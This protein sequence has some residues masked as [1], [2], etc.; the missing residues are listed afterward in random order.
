[1]GLVYNATTK[2][3]EYLVDLDGSNGGGGSSKQVTL[4]SVTTAPS[5]T[6]EK[7]S[8][9]YNSTN[10][11]IY[12]AVDDNTWTGATTSTP[13]FGVIYIYSNN[14]A[15]TYYQ[16]DGDNLVETDLEKYQLVANKT[17]DYTESSKNKYPSSYALYK[18]LAGVRPN[19]VTN[20][21]ATLPATTG[22]SLGDTFLNTSDKKLYTAEANVY[23]LN[24]T[25]FSSATISS[26]SVLDTTTGVLSNFGSLKIINIG[27]IN[28][29]NPCNI[30]IPIK[31]GSNIQNTQVVFFA[32]T[33]GGSNWYDQITI[34]IQNGKMYLNSNEIISV[35]TETKYII[36]IKIELPSQYYPN[37]NISVSVSDINGNILGTQTST[38]DKPSFDFVFGCW[39]GRGQEG[40]FFS[41]EIYA[42]IG[43][44][45]FTIYDKN[46][47]S[48]SLGWDSG[49]SLTEGQYL[50]TTNSKLIFYKDDEITEV[51]DLSGYKLKATTTTIDTASVTVSEIKANTNYVFSNNA[52]T[53]I[54]LTAC[55]TSFEETSINFTTGSSAPTFTD[56]ASIKWFGGVPEMKANTTYTIVIFNKQAY[57]QEQ[58]NV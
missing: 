57:W 12:T 20:S 42:H 23:S 55:E 43:T 53:D 16:W 17:D 18:G 5:G 38:C 33:T 35:E 31:T 6:F 41:G 45:F 19:A 14:G 11:V 56:N 15:T 9:Y 32:R 54:T 30:C 13:E 46:V 47:L 52:I 36:D 25:D 3:T 40:S 4:L 37:N 44:H 27:H 10:K 48:A 50:D 39:A 29:G 26:A 8:Q 58:E 34:N 51:V 21:G 24:T 7:G 22:Y 1:M 2:Q 49:T 28:V